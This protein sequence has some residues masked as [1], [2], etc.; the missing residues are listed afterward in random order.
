MEIAQGSA[1]VA[2]TAAHRATE[3]APTPAATVAAGE[4]TNRRAAVPA[5]TEG[6]PNPSLNATFTDTNHVAVAN[7]TVTIN[8]GD[9]TAPSTN[10]GAGADP[11]LPI[12]QIGGAGGTTY[13][14][15]DSHIFPEESGST[16]PPFSFT[17]TLTVTETANAANTDTKAATAQV[18]DAALVP[19][20]PVAPVIANTVIGGNTGN[21]TTAA[22]AEAALST[23]APSKRPLA[24]APPASAFP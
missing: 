16:V 10:H 24:A 20:D 18:L 7:L 21:A 22:Q 14:I 4:R 9:G 12:T 13:T 6:A 23:A 19:G 3:R 17:V 15:T 8:Y 11:N 2:P 5:A 1:A